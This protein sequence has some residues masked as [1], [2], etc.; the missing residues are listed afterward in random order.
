MQVLDKVYYNANDLPP[1][2]RDGMERWIEQGITPGSF[3]RAVLRNDLKE[4]VLRADEVS[5][6]SLSL[7]IRWLII[8]APEGSYGSDKVFSQWPLYLTALRR[9]E[10]SHGEA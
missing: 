4:A 5:F 6:A 9:Q 10:A 7:I 1:H 3:L 2:L 8:Y